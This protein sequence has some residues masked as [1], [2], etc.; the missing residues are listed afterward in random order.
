MRSLS[1]IMDMLQKIWTGFIAPMMRRPAR[2]QVAALCW[3]QGDAGLEVLLITS[4][5]TGRWVIPKG[6]PKKGRSG[7]Q[8]AAEEAWEEAGVRL[9]QGT[10]ALVGR[11]H[12]LKRMKGNLPID[13]AVDVYAMQVA[14]LEDSYPETGQRERAWFSLQQAALLVD[15]PELGLILRERLQLIPNL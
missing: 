15:E 11:Y 13:T 1:G 9:A 14:H 3:R 7:A 5:G 4:R 2:Y 6:W 10:T 12:Y 8:T